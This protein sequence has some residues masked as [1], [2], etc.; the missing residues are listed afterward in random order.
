MRNCLLAQ[1]ALTW[2]DADMPFNERVKAPQLKSLY[3]LFQLCS[4]VGSSCFDGLRVTE[5]ASSKR[6]RMNCVLQRFFRFQAL[7]WTSL[8]FL[9]STHVVVSNC[10]NVVWS[11][12]QMDRNVDR[13]TVFSWVKQLSSWQALLDA[14]L[15]VKLLEPIFSPVRQ[16]V[17][18]CISGVELCK[19]V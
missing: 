17:Y 19:Y 16:T 5:G 3:A 18:Y 11:I 13:T 14:I 9:S 2:A 8:S 6:Q 12:Q 4:N 15:L 7:L 10:C 1:A